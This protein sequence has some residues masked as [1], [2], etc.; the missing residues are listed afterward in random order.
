MRGVFFYI[1]QDY[2]QWRKQASTSM[3]RRR[4]LLSVTVTVPLA[5]RHTRKR[6]TRGEHNANIKVGG[7]ATV[8][9]TLTNLA[10]ELTQEEQALV[11]RVNF[12]PSPGG[13]WDAIADAVET[14]MNRLL[15]RKAI[16]AA[17]L[18]FIADARYNVGGHGSSR[19]EII[20]RNGKPLPLFRNPAFLK[21][22]HYCLYGPDLDAAVIEEFKLKVIACGEPF[23]GSDALEVADFARQL[24][25][26]R[27]LDRHKAPTEFYKLALDC[28]L[29]ADDARSV[30]DSVMTVR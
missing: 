22:L 6:C 14:L 26:S 7:N 16:P 30:R 19:S 13:D 23:T 29:D 18:K 11:G 21:H 5:L 20:E 27:G 9:T 17:R 12:H 8:K 15:E 4:P 2:R 24:T 1:M 28:G 3:L 25:R 10:I